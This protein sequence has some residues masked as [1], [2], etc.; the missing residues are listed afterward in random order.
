MG[1]GLAD[2]RTTPAAPARH[3]VMAR[4]R[5]RLPAR[6]ARAQAALDILEGGL[7]RPHD[8]IMTYP[9]FQALLTDRLWT[10]DKKAPE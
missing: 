6:I 5:E 10:P 3:E 2:I 9:H 4:H 8:D 1:S 7:G